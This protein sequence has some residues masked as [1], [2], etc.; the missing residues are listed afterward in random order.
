MPVVTAATRTR[1]C[2][3][4]AA[5][6]GNPELPEIR[7]IDRDGIGCRRPAEWNTSPHEDVFAPIADP[8]LTRRYRRWRALMAEATGI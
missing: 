5:A 1:C 6:F 7:T 8:A 3:I 2:R 4:S